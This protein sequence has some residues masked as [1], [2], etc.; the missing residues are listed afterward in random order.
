MMSNPSG[1]RPN[2]QPALDELKEL[3]VLTEQCAAQARV[4][5]QQAQSY[6]AHFKMNSEE[7]RKLAARCRFPEIQARLLRIAAANERLGNI[8]EG[9]AA[10]SEPV[11]S[12]DEATVRRSEDPVSQARRHVAEAE[13]RVE[14]QE[15]LAAK[16]SD[17]GKNLQLADQAREILGTLKQTLRLARDHLALELSK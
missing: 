2:V 15:A 12:E 1:S 8:A 9:H 6:A 16:L 4:A 14:R 13:V 3:L 17:S 7:F 10:P 11:A 5:K